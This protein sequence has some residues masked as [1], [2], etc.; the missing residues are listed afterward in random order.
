MSTI[1]EIT[2]SDGKDLA[3]LQEKVEEIQAAIGTLRSKTDAAKQQRHAEEQRY[4]YEAALVELETIAALAPALESAYQ[5]AAAQLVAVADKIRS[6]RRRWR[7]LEG[8]VNRFEHDNA[9]PRHG[10][11]PPH[12]PFAIPESFLS[13]AGPRVPWDQWLAEWKEDHRE[14]KS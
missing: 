9:L 10:L 5:D 6:G 11:R 13:D 3:A 14:W 12:M 1:A 2:R 8:G 7:E 4:R